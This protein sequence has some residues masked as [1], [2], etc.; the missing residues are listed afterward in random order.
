MAY[1]PLLIPAAT[2]LPFV[3]ASAWDKGR[4]ALLLAWVLVAPLL[5]YAPISVQRR[6]LESVIVPL[7]ILAAI[8]LAGWARHGRAGRFAAGGMIALSSLSVVILVLGSLASLTQTTTPLYRPASETAALDWLNTHAPA[9]AVV[10]GAFESGNVVPVHTRL[11][12]FVGHGPETIAAI[13]KTA[14]VRAFFADA[15]TPA[16]RE[17]LLA[18]PCLAPNSVGCSDP[19]DFVLFGPLEQAIAGNTTPGRWSEGLTRIYETGGY[20]IFSVTATEP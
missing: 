18:G 7:S 9:H 17:A 15:M 20:Q 10:L 8:G 12:P 6:L 1:L 4:L 5:A 16:E 19:I 14:L 2:A 3:W 13:E 11:R